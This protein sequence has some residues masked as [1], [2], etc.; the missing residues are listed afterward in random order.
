[1]D[2]SDHRAVNGISRTLV[3][4]AILGATLAGCTRPVVPGSTILRETL[5]HR[6]EVDSAFRL[7]PNSPFLQDSTIQYHGLHWFE[8]D[9][10]FY[11]VAKLHR[12]ADP[13]EL[14]IYGTKGEERPMLRY[15]YF[16]ISYGGKEYPLNVYTAAEDTRSAGRDRYL[17]VW[18][19]DETTGRETYPVGRYVDVGEEH[20]DP[21]QLYTLN[22]NNA[23]N[24][25]CAYSSR[26]SCAVP[27]KENRLPFPV[28]AG[29]MK[30]HP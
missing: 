19:T 12:Y 3:F 18:F 28:R 23:Y 9:T 11:F 21:E 14:T 30:Y 7:D 20:S 8:P 17:S 13:A 2:R 5:A 16:L 24:P 22:F 4:C 1:M 26:Y 6:A 27:T 25:Y 10:T 29:E 15:G